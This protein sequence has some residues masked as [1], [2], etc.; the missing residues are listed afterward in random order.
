MAHPLP[1]RSDVSPGHGSET[2][3]PVHPPTGPVHA[4]SGASRNVDPFAV[5]NLGYGSPG[6]SVEMN[7]SPLKFLL[8]T[9]IWRW[10][11]AIFELGLGTQEQRAVVSHSENLLTSTLSVTWRES[12]IMENVVEYTYIWALCCLLLEE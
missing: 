7:L 1:T 2:S 9:Y 10:H 4:H 6:Q 12:V 5:I 8:L 11:I 3:T